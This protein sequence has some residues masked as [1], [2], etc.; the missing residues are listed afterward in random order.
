MAGKRPKQEPGTYGCSLCNRDDGVQWYYPDSQE[1]LCDRCNEV[2]ARGKKSKSDRVNVG[3]SKLGDKP[4]P[5]TCTTHAGKLCDMY[6][7]DC[8]TLMCLMCFSQTHKQHNWKLLEDEFSC[9]KEQ[10]KAQVTIISAKIA[11]YQNETLNRHC[12]SKAF[13]DNIDSIREQVNARRTRL[14]AEV[15]YVADAVLD[16]LSTLE[17]DESEVQQT[18]CQKAE[19]KVAELTFMHEKAVTHMSSVSMFET[20]RLLRRTLPLYDTDVE[21]DLPKPP[22]FFP[23][24]IN[25]LTLAK[26]LGQV[27]KEKQYKKMEI[28]SKHVQCLSKF[29]VTA[30]SKQI[31]G[32]CPVDDNHAWLSILHYKGL[33]LVDRK[34]TVTDKVELDFCPYRMAMVGQTDILMT[35]IPSD[36]FVYK[37]SRC[38]K[39]VTVFAHIDQRE[40]QDISINEIGEVLISNNTS[41]IVVLNQSGK[42]SRKF[43][44]GFSGL[45][46]TCLSS[47]RLGITVHV[48]DRFVAENLM[49]TDES[50]LVLQTW[51][52]ELRSGQKI[53]SKHL[54]KMSCDKYDR[55]YIPDYKNNQV[56]VLPK[57][58]R[59]AS[60]LLDKTHLVIRPT[61]VEV[62]MCGHVWI[63][64]M[65]GTVHIMQ[66]QQ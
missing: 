15:D 30:P 36:G 63:G 40:I 3:E 21:I 14:K 17:E 20:E 37:L 2:H 50:G 6:C 45:N 43:T 28:E 58:S 52:G 41:E 18:A 60:C 13:K 62:D 9:K 48:T 35:S 23:E 19:E 7:C 57:D 27:H 51:T 64:C 8:N 59:M 12:T 46:I 24:S 38:T 34:G 1:I 29:T 11:H 32:I 5:E 22:L 56:Y 42:V 66:L 39:Q 33:T 4:V 65:D 16:E 49:I 26:M 10:L 61:V 31:L 55:L 53:R 25:R 47:R 54:C 44:C